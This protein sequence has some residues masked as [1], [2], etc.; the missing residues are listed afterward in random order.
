MFYMELLAL[1][2]LSV[3]LYNV[4]AIVK[5]LQETM[6]FRFSWSAQLYRNLVQVLENPS[7]FSSLMHI[8]HIICMDLDILSAKIKCSFSHECSFLIRH[9]S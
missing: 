6:A 8:L 3:D 9:H 7:V 5:E 4:E 2:Q 1:H